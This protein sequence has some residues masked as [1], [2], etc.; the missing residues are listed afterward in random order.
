M[1]KIGE[2]V[3]IK[4]IKAPNISIHLKRLIGKNWLT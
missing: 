4:E 2:E 1:A 3:D